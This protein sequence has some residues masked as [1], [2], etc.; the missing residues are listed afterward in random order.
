MNRT[1][2]GAWFT[3]GTASL[4]I[5]FGLLIFGAMFARGS[6]TAGVGWVKLWSW[7]ILLFLAVGIALLMRKQSP[8]EP[9]SDERDRLIKRNAVLASF[10]SVWVLIAIATVLPL[11]VVG[12]SGSIPVILLPI[13]NVGIVLG[14]ML[15]HSVAVLVQYGRGGEHG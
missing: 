1:Q 6:R 4:L 8:A 12:D 5:I 3:L 10:I 11:F 2:K 7:L 14:A 9:K 13:I 15:V